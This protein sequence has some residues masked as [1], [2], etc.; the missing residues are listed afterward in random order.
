MIGSA[1]TLPLIVWNALAKPGAR[2]LFLKFLA[3]RKGS[4]GVTGKVPGCSSTSPES[5]DT[6][7][8]TL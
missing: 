8:A 2:E 5:T 6:M 4:I 1:R 7:S 3:C